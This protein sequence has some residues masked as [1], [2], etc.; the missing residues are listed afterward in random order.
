MNLRYLIN[1]DGALLK[2]PLSNK[3]IFVLKLDLLSN[4]LWKP[5]KGS[6]TN[7]IKKLELFKARFLKS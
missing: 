2:K 3:S 4:I 1:S 6:E 7:K 5:K